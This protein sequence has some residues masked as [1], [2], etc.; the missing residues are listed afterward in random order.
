LSKW[1][2][3]P[4]TTDSQNHLDV[5]S[6]TTN[7]MAVVAFLYLIYS[8]TLFYLFYSILFSYLSRAVWLALVEE[9]NVTV[10]YDVVKG[11]K[12]SLRREY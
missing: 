5:D 6:V 2:W 10:T 4:L 7:L 9:G 3:P 8:A 12:A 1:T 11:K